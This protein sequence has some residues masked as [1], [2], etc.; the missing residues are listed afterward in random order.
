[1]VVVVVVVVVVF[2]VKGVATA[3]VKGWGAIIVTTLLRDVMCNIW[4]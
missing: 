2:S 4:V 1:L 3:E